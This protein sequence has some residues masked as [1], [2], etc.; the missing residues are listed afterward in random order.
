MVHWPAPAKAFWPGRT[1]QARPGLAS[2]NFPWLG[3][4]WPGQWSANQ[5]FLAKARPW[6]NDSMSHTDKF[7]F[8]IHYFMLSFPIKGNGESD[9]VVEMKNKDVF[10]LADSNADCNSNVFVQC[11]ISPKG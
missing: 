5:I 4:A 1:G 6:P 10:V 9:E 11:N 2:K 7:F 8:Q 3:L